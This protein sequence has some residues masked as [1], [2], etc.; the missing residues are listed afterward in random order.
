MDIPKN[1]LEIISRKIPS[2]LRVVNELEKISECESLIKKKE[3]TQEKVKKT[4]ENQMKSFKA[5][6]KNHDVSPYYHTLEYVEEI[7]RDRLDSFEEKI[8][9][10]IQDECKAVGE[11]QQA[12]H[13]IES[14]EQDCHQ[15][16]KSLRKDGI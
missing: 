15:N 3:E 9:K 4:I 11:K 7:F 16:G 13:S 10:K 1:L 14:K 6:K 2:S 5:L 12:N 8:T